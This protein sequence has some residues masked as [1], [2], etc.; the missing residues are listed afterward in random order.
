MRIFRLGRRI[1]AAHF[2]VAGIVAILV[3][4]GAG[5][6]LLAT[7]E[8]IPVPNEKEPIQGSAI[9]LSSTRQA[10]TPDPA[11]RRDTIDGRVRQQ[12]PRILLPQLHGWDGREVP[13]L[14]I[15]RAAGYKTRGIQAPSPCVN[16]GLLGDTTC[17]LVSGN[18]QAGYRALTALRQYQLDAPKAAGD[19]GNAWELALAYDLLSLH[20][21]LTDLDR[22]TVQLKLEKALRAD[23]LILDGDSASLWHGR[24]T[25]ASDAWLCAMELDPS[26]SQRANLIR[27]AQ[28]HF[29]DVMRA[30]ALVVAWPEGYNYWINNRAFLVALAGSAYVNGVE[31]SR[32][33]EEIRR[34]LG[35]VG[36]WTVYATRPDNR[37]EG[38]GDEGSRVDLKDETRRVIDIIAQL[39]RDPV[40]STFSL[41]LGRLHGEASYYIGYRWG[42]WL[43][44][45]PDVSPVAT[46]APGSPQGL[47]E[48]LPHAAIFGH[49]AMNMAYIRSGWGPDDTFISVHAG[50][51]FTHHGHYDAG[52]FTIFKG[53]PLAINSSTYGSFTSPNRLDYSI[54]T[55]AKN[56][57]LVLRPGEK[58]QPNH[59]FDVDVA[60][61]GQRVVLPTGSA[62]RS[63]RD[64]Y[65][66]LSSGLHLRAGK[67]LH[68]ENAP[69]Q[70]AYLA[71]DLTDAYNTPDHDEGGSGG[72]VS[73]VRRELLYLYDEDR[74]IVYDDVTA[75]DATYTKKW[76]LHTVNKPDV[77]N[78]RVLKGSADDGILESQSH[79]AIVRNGRGYLNVHAVY[80]L[81]VVMRLVG[82]P[83]YQFYVE[84]DGD[85]KTLN[86][87]NFSQGA[88]LAPWFD[89]GLWRI[90]LQP[91]VPRKRDQFLVV[92]SPSI[93]TG[94][95]AS[96][97]PLP[98][99]SPESRGVAL[100]K[101]L[102][103]FADIQRRQPL[104]F[105][106]TGKQTRL[107]AI[108]VPPA[109]EVTLKYGE[110]SRT[111]KASQ[112]GMAT[113]NLAPNGK[114]SAVLIR[115]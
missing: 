109:T 93:A 44:N 62:I 90:E 13:A 1:G 39:T 47:G 51:I 115:N 112:S 32:Y 80:P 46:V 77:A 83:D 104:R 79:D 103:I 111:E 50:D 71:A 9:R 11:V 92:L 55:I 31:D 15:E 35:R 3:A 102:V 76:L 33:T 107:Y 54:R 69:G 97:T 81:D 6:L 18:E 100:A 75:V 28:S 10:L 70:Y 67:L 17:W 74:L 99:N 113:F 23:L 56:S 88:N 85:D 8:A 110:M 96:V 26:T 58:V 114:R 43:F 60:D 22:T 5:V 36:L 49:D 48:V 73:S 66:N 98:T 91:G 101:S 29:V 21:G 95:T 7:H 52:H 108:G 34:I 72:K 42:F 64:W 53:A 105:D 16:N 24:T 68:F 65:E 4:T 2:L 86:G 87:R 61:G 94:R 84:T 57:L 38:F 82:G 20:P 40:M 12:H 41:Y 106:V 63:V 27:R 45:D 25:L 59:F 19:Y 78:V 30:L 37:I 89:I 14:F